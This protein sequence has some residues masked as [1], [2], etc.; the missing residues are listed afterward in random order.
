MRKCYTDGDY[1]DNAWRLLQGEA[2]KGQKEE[3]KTEGLGTKG[4]KMQSLKTNTKM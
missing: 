2:V 4:P 1:G 3:S